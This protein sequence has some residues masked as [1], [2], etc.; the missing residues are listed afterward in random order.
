MCYT[1]NHH[2]IMQVILTIII[3]EVLYEGTHLDF[4]LCSSLSSAVVS[5]HSWGGGGCRVITLVLC[6]AIQGRIRI[7]MKLIMYVF[8]EMMPQAQSPRELYFTHATKP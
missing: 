1:H 2:S 4:N 3:I 6:P 5:L 7:V 8:P